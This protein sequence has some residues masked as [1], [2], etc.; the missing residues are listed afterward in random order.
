L[1]RQ[2]SQASLTQRE[3][4]KSLGWSPSKIIRIEQGDVGI[5][6]SDLW[7][8]LKLYKVE[9]TDFAAEL[10]EMARGSRKL[11]FSDYADV[12]SDE[13][14]R[15]FRYEASASL[16]RQFA[17]A[18]IPGLLQTDDYA[19]SIFT[20]NQ[21]N[22]VTAA[23]LLASRRDRR[24][25]LDSSDA[26]DAFFII[27]E[28]ALW[29]VV[30]GPEVMGP[31]L[32]HLAAMAA[33]ARVKIQVLPFAAGAHP[34]LAGPFNLLEFASEDD[35]DVLFVENPMGDVLYH[36]DPKVTSVYRL[37]FWE[38]EDLAAEATDFRRFLAA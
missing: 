31:Q 21:L 32:D 36:D 38:L 17:Q 29:R 12:V 25:L 5:T 14:L 3:V 13:L 22:D 16:I 20:T 37:R 26:P 19:R 33:R 6:V 28:G 7:A 34:A 4:A 10:E 8:L 15:Y 30:G 9:D 2:R 18:V 24:A 23:K 35:P 11:P 1:R 27:D